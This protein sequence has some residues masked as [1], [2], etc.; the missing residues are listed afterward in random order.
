MIR[1]IPVRELHAAWLVLALLSSIALGQKATKPEGVAAVLQPLVDSHSLAGAVTLV[2]DREK[3]LDVGT[4]GYGDVKSG[5]PMTTDAV[6]WIASQ[7]KPI[8]AAALMML[9]DE[10]KVALDDPVSKYVPEFKD[11]WLAVEQ[12]RD[13]MLL[14]RPA[15]PVSVRDLLRHTSGLPFSSMMERPTLDGLA[16]SYAVR[17]YAMTPLQFEPGTKYQYSNAGINTAGRI[18]EVASGMA[19]E[20]FL[21]RRLFG[22]LGMK[23]TTFWPNSEQ[24]KRLAHAYKPNAAKDDLEETTIGQLR[25]PLDERTRKPMPAGGL[26]STANDVARFCQM[27]LNGGTF[28]RRRYLSED[29]VREMTRRQTGEEIKES[30]G[31]GLSTGPDGFGHGGAFATNMTVDSRRGLVYVFLVQHAGFPGE[32]GKAFSIFKKAAEDPYGRGGE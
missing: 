28:E 15:R 14:K 9:V 31:L 16:L 13:H 25:Y 18:I 26:F 21:D 29:A 11:L 20:E 1:P 24:L 12:D 5:K 23:D 19:Y 10:G 27:M 22:P 6:F 2:A 32:G 4:V 30:Y 17:S 7:S 8:T 3:I